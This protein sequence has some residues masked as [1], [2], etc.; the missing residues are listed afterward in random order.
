[1]Q[2]EAL[3]R[4]MR[5]YE[6]AH[7]HRVLPG[8]WMVARLDGRSFTRLVREIRPFEAPFDP[9]FRD[10]MV[11]T[12]RHL[13]DCGFNVIY[14]NTHSDEIS[15]LFH[16][17]EDSFGRKLRKLLSILA[18][19]ASAAFSLQLGAV[20]VFD[21]RIAQLPS[22]QLVVDYFRW[23]AED[24]HRNALN[25][26]CYW[27]LRGQGLEARA[28]DVQVAGMSVAAK[29][30]LL[31]QHGTNFNDLPAWQKRGVG[32]LWERYDTAGT[33]PQTGEAVVSSRRRLRILEELPA[34]EAYSAWVAEL[35]RVQV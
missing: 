19:E 12:A 30:E 4:T 28:A 7:D 26:H 1:M 11:T 32:L 35:L 29:N 34:R 23:R 17:G 14:A 24:A 22:E 15:L 27:L 9:R 5:V 8:L 6:T 20:A 3:D 16:P 31:F 21:A 2:F 13:M 18:G 25:A 33:N 10:L